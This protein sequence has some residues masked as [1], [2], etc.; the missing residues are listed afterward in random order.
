MRHKIS[1]RNFAQLLGLSASAPA[2]LIAEPG[3]PAHPETTRS[4]QFP[5]GFLWGTAT[6]AYQI[7]GAPDEDGRGLSI[8]DTFSRAKKTYTGENGDIADDH[9][10]R[11]REDV[12]LMRDLGIQAYQF[13]V[14]WPRIFP[15]G[16]GTPNPK[17]WG[18][19]DRLLDTLLEAG[20]QPWCC[21]YHWDLPEALI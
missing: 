17:G 4:R 8:W 7:E 19:Y 20:I 21:L 3:A 6:S 15:N 1:R 14:A 18:F 10:H 9:F 16:T 11:Y 12:A 2:L 13:S 5:K